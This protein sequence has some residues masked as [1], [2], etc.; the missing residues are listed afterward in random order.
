MA[1]D[2]GQADD[3]ADET[4]LSSLAAVLADYKVWLMALSLTAMVRLHIR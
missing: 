2:S 1:E 3:E 4:P